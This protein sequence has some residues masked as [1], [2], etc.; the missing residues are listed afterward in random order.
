M[1]RLKRFQE[2]FH[3]REDIPCKFACPRSQHLIRNEI[4]SIGSTVRRVEWYCTFWR[5]SKTALC[6]PSG[7]FLFHS[8]S[9]KIGDFCHP[10][11]RQSFYFQKISDTWKLNIFFFCFLLHRTIA[12]KNIWNSVWFH[13]FVCPLSGPMVKTNTIF[14]VSLQFWLLNKL[15][16]APYV[17]RWAILSP[18]MSQAIFMTSHTTFHETHHHQM[19]H[20]I[21][22]W[23]TLSL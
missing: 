5:F 11:A 14:L 7:V 22:K 3:F 17:S 8:N 15:R 12:K 4:L 1:N 19:S 18:S 13:I 21:C 10:H 9:Q 23:S 6:C 20:T 16:N 2:L